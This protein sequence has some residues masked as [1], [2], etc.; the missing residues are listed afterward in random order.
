MSQLKRNRTYGF[1][2]IAAAYLATVAVGIAV[3]Y[4]LA[5]P[6]LLWRIFIADLIATLLIWMVGLFF[7]NSSIYD[8]YWSVAPS[9]I[10]PLIAGHSG[11][12]SVGVC[13]M[14]GVILFWG[15]R[16]TL[17]W[18]HTFENLDTQDWRYTKIKQGHPRLWFVTNLFGIHLFPT[19]V[20]FLVMIPAI[21]FIVYAAKVNVG[22]ILSMLL[23]IGAVLLQLVSDTQ[24]RHFRRD[25]RNVGKVMDRGLWKYSRHPNYLGEIFMWWG[26]Y[27]MALFSGV[28]PWI[29]LVGPLANT[30][31]F[32]GVSVPL[33][34]DRLLGNKKGYAEYK[35]KTGMLLP[36]LF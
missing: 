29:A 23:C 24:M 8:P 25:K 2:V 28:S 19:L 17:N 27:F 30:L 1:L 11:S 13:L 35:T 4:A 12:L 36:K 9:V 31:M 34:E 10:I 3:F 7:Q 14:I 18:A 6:S 32:L 33:M 16:L 20:V 21:Q 5:A 15:V 26:I 22:V